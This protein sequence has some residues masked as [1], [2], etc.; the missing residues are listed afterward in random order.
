MSSEVLHFLWKE[1][2][3]YKQEQAVQFYNSSIYNIFH[4]T[5]A[6]AKHYVKEGRKDVQNAKELRV[7]VY[8]FL[9]TRQHART[10]EKHS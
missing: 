8:N 5:K 10:S 6:S 7:K 3:E 2:Q 4:L 9:N 1:P